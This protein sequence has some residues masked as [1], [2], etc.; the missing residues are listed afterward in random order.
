MSHI[1]EMTIMDPFKKNSNYTRENSDKIS[2]DI[3]LMSLYV[4]FK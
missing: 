4:I 1:S 3:C 2:L